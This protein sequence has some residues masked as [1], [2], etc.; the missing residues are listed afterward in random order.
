MEGYTT[1]NL[2]VPN[3]RKDILDLLR[4]L[5]KSLHVK[6]KEDT[7]EDISTKLKEFYKMAGS[8]D[9]ATTDEEANEY[10]A[11]RYGE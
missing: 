6:T 10:R 2:E 7:K 5:A 8:V 4:S 3:D 1:F 11:K 9:G